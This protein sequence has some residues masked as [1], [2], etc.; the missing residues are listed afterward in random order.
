MLGAYREYFHDSFSELFIESAQNDPHEITDWINDNIEI[1]NSRQ[2]Y[3]LPI[4]PRGVHDLLVADV[5]SVN[6]F[7]VALCRSFGVPA[8]LE[9]GTYTP[10]YYENN[11]WEDVFFDGKKQ[12]KKKYQIRFKAVDKDLKF[13]PQYYHHFTLAAFENKRFNTIRL[14]EYQD[15]DKI[16][17][18]EL[19]AGQYRL[20]TSNRL[21][22]G[23]ILV[24]MSYFTLD[25]DRTIDL[26]FPEAG[27]ET[28]VLGTLS[29]DKL[30]AFINYEDDNARN[31]Q[32]SSD[33]VILIIQPD[34]EPS[35]HM[36][37]DLQK[38]QKN[39]DQLKN[40]IVFIT[41]EKDMSATF[42]VSNY[43]HLPLRSVFKTANTSPSELLDIQMDMDPESYPK[44]LIANEKGEIYY[45]IEGYKIGIGDDLL[46]RL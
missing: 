42:K 39:F 15:I 3:D 43:P 46:K 41:P 40:T 26:E 14:G 4:T 29:R 20:I 5:R 11:K 2:S 16:G 13:T 38:I 1:D 37:N 28:T 35:K 27:T 44:V 30:T 8:R 34:R 22:S 25:S 10:Q 24:N 9:T 23:K 19:G 45:Y 36:L 17:P 32:A 33:V 12:I 18:L 6:I 21:A 31:L 7:F